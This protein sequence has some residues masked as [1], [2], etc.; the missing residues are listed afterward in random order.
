MTAGSVTPA[1]IRE[2]SRPATDPGVRVLGHLAIAVQRHRI[3]PALS[4]LCREAVGECLASLA[5]LATRDG[6]RAETSDPSGRAPAEDGSGSLEAIDSTLLPAALSELVDGDPAEADPGPGAAPGVSRAPDRRGEDEAGE[7]RI[8]VAPH[9]LHLDLAAVPGSTAIDELAE[10][11]YRADVEEVTI[12]TDASATEIARFARQVA[13]WDRSRTVHDSLAEAIAEQGITRIRVRSTDRLDVLEFDVLPATQLEVLRAEKRARED[14]AA[15]VDSAIHKAWVRVETDCPL[16]P[17]DMV[18]LA[19]LVD[20]HADLARILVGMA[21]GEGQSIGAPMAL[22]QTVSELIHL[23]SDLSDGAART[24]FEELARTIMELEPEARRTLTRDV[25]LPD[26]M[27]SGRAARVL[28]LMPDGEIVEALRT[29]VDLEAGAPGLM[30]LALERLSLPADRLR[31]LTRS[32]TDDVLPPAGFHIVRGAGD[33]IEESSRIRLA[34]DGSVLRDLREYSALEL[35]V[36][37]ETAGTLEQIRSEVVDMDDAAER[38]RCAI[39]LIPHVRN[40]DR[41]TGILDSVTGLLRP[42]LWE[43]ARAAAGQVRALREVSE[44]LE[45]ADPEVAEAISSVLSGLLGPDYVQFQAQRWQQAEAP[46][47]G[48]LEILDAFGSTAATAFMEALELE[49]RRAVRHGILDFVCAHAEVFADGV[50]VYLTDPRWT[51]VRNAVRVLGFAGPAGEVHLAATL[52]HSDDRVVRETFLAL[53]RIG[54]PR[55]AEE[56]LGQLGSGEPKRRDLAQEA[57]RRFPAAEGERLARRLLSKPQ[58]W[59]DRPQV[60]RVLIDRFMRTGAPGNEELL[61][62]LLPLR[63]QFWRP[64][65]MGLGWTA[66]SALR[67]AAR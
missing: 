21:E 6:E 15:G 33:G 54:T 9:R 5:A 63:F 56:I 65:R 10:R 44:S 50:R 23:Y 45:V 49:D 53:S 14:E 42:L 67:E 60:A 62:A 4:P 19:F 28:R 39:S 47:P 25:L 3:Y 57:I 52:R 59:T 34:S 26:L 36:D 38:L 13:A 27:E 55:A 41:A 22:R 31:T 29:L 32:V 48:V 61:R 58:L 24:R 40:P 30:G 35:A 43:D 12:R 17:I 1:T 20:S 66:S 46:D 11:L 7:L 8:R 16:E 18:D 51:C 37:E 2:R 64:A